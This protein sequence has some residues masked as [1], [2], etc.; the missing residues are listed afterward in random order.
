MSYR[1][2]RTRKRALPFLQ[3]LFP[4]TLQACSTGAVERRQSC[5]YTGLEVRVMSRQ[6]S[7]RQS[8]PAVWV[9]FCYKQ[10]FVNACLVLQNLLKHF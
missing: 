6:V 5:K 7:T 10:A 2:F 4:N 9:S 1:I 3:V 8:L